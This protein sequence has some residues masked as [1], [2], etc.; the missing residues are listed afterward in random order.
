[1]GNN[2]GRRRVDGPNGDTLSL[3]DRALAEIQKEGKQPGEF[4]VSELFNAIDQTIDETTIRSRANRMVR[5]GKWIRRQSGKSVFY[6]FP[7]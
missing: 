6:R 7:D 5:E 1:V 4:T 3:V 2:K